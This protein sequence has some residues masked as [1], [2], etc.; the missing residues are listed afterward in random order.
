MSAAE[1]GGCVEVPEDLKYTKSHEWIKVEGDVARIG[2]SDHAQEQLN[3]IVFVDLPEEGKTVAAGDAVCVIE[4]T[5]AASDVY[6]PV[7]GVVTVLNREL[8]TAPEKVNSSPYEEGWLFEVKMS[9]SGEVDGLLSAEQ[10]KKM[11]EE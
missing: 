8:E 1:E 6:A 2:I 4:S 9:Q 7:S 11:I 10:Y 5:K 3:D